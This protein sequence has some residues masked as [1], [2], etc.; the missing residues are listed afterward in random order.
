MSVISLNLSPFALPLILHN[1]PRFYQKPGT[2]IL[3]PYSGIEKFL[4]FQIISDEK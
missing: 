4:W 1:S 2:H 3:R